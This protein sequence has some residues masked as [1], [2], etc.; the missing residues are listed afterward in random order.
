M[1]EKAPRNLAPSVLDRLR[2]FSRERNEDFNLVLTRY[3][4]ER[5][6]HRLTKS[7]F[8]DQFVLKGAA[9]FFIWTG[10]AHRPTR[11]LD[12]LGLGDQGLDAVAGVFRSICRTEVTPDAVDLDAS[13]VKA[14]VIREDQPYGGIRVRMRA[15]IGTAVIPLQIDIGFGD[16]ITPAASQLTIDS[17]LDLPATTIAAYPP[18]TVVAEKLEAMVKLGI[19]NTRMK[20][21][22]DLWVLSEERAFHLDLLRGAVQATFARRRTAIPESWPIGLTGD[23]ATEE[24]KLAQWKAFLSVHGFT[25]TRIELA[26]V[27]AKLRKFAGAPLGLSDGGG[28]SW[29]PGGPWKV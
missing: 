5:L 25:G 23:F 27:I 18:E 7:A 20:D 13:S 4:G 15:R 12:L 24:S 16:A 9:L 8:G 11:D 19:A 10:R 14:V 17:M 1:S 21:F 3:A 2:N 22:Y 28:K 29:V 6:L 26:G